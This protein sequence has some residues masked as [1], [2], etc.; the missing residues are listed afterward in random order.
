MTN[1]TRVHCYYGCYL[2]SE[3]PASISDATVDADVVRFGSVVAT[4]NVIVAIVVGG[5]HFRFVCSDFRSN[6]RPSNSS[7]SRTQPS[8]AVD[9]SS[10]VTIPIERR[11]TGRM[12]RQ[13]PSTRS[14][15][16]SSES[17]SFLLRDPRASSECPQR[18]RGY[19]MVVCIRQINH[20]ERVRDA[21]A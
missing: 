9:E 13:Q 1:N 3:W 5:R 11:C 17:G 14:S 16:S 12:Q 10:V 2:R 21:I 19:S 15:V 20:L 6:F 7:S 8:S 4:A 18:P